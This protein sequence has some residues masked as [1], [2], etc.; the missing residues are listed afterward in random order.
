MLRDEQGA[1]RREGGLIQ[2][3]P[4]LLASG[5]FDTSLTFWLLCRDA[6]LEK[7]DPC[8]LGIAW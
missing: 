1:G 7:R 3:D 8:T 2:L 5:F 6:W 4:D